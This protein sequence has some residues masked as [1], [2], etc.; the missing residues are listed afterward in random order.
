MD[1]NGLDIFAALAKPRTGKLFVFSG[2]S[3]A[4]KTTVCRMLMERVDGLVFS[5]SHTTRPKRDGETEGEDYFFVSDEEFENLSRDGAFAEQA[6]V[7]NHRYGT[8]RAFVDEK[9]SAGLDV[10]LDIDVQGA[11]QISEAYRD[12]AATIF[13]ITPTLDVLVE[14]LR[15]RGTDS[16]EVLATRIKNAEAELARYV[17]FKYYLINDDL[18]TCVRDAEGIIR[19]E[20]LL[21]SDII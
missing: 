14:R 8:S 1:E 10:L 7:H 11:A 6:V 21:V 20:R 4:G 18:D 9:T 3:G 5:V 16:P 15:R 19:A 12:R 17:E 2:P 13:I